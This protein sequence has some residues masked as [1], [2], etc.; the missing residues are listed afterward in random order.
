MHG[1]IVQLLKYIKG[2]RLTTCQ[3]GENAVKIWK[4]ALHISGQGEIDTIAVNAR[5]CGFGKNGD[6]DGRLSSKA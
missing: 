1:N 5:G 4:Q 3:A 2:M 6:G